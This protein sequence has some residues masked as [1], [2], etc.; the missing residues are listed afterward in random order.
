[1]IG[2]VL[3]A[4]LTGVALAG[5]VSTASRR[6]ESTAIFANRG[7][8]VRAKHYRDVGPDCANV[9]Y[10][11]IAIVSAPRGGQIELRREGEFPNFAANNPR[12]K[13]NNRRAEGVGVYY[14]PNP[15]FAGP[16]RFTID[17]IWADGARW[18]EDFAVQ[19]R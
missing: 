12:A 8:A 6:V 1:M 18:S 9:G 4:A 15:A 7:E 2:K 3:I 16:D 5:C 13:C 10:A 19:V 11:N 14:K 17:I